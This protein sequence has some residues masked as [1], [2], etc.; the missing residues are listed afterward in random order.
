[1]ASSQQEGRP[2]LEVDESEDVK[3]FASSPPDTG[4]GGTCL[5][6]LMDFFADVSRQLQLFY[7]NHFHRERILVFML[8]VAAALYYADV[9]LDV[10]AAKVF[11]ERDDKLYLAS[12]LGGIGIAG[13]VSS[14]HGGHFVFFQPALIVY[15]AW[16]LLPRRSKLQPSLEPGRVV[17]DSVCLKPSAETL[18]KLLAL[19]RDMALI[20]ANEAFIEAP[21]NTH[22]SCRL[23][24][25][26]AG[27]LV[28]CYAYMHESDLS[29]QDAS[30][31]LLSVIIGIISSGKALAELDKEGRVMESCATI[32]GEF[33]YVVGT[34]LGLLEGIMLFGYRA[35]ETFSRIGLLAHLQQAFRSA[36]PEEF[37]ARLVMAIW[38][39]I[40]AGTLLLLGSR[41]FPSHHHKAIASAFA[42]QGP[43]LHPPHLKVG[44]T[45]ALLH[46]SLRTAEVLAMIFLCHHWQTD[47]KT[48][49]KAAGIAAFAFVLLTPCV[50]FYA[51]HRCTDQ[52]LSDM[53]RQLLPQKGADTLAWPVAD[54]RPS[55]ATRFLAS[56]GFPDDGDIPEGM[57]LRDMNDNEAAQKAMF[58][59]EGVKLVK[60]IDF[61]RSR[62]IMASSWKKIMRTLAGGAAEELMLTAA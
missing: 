50:L 7:H 6:S 34:G 25:V 13:L 54:N 28:Q 52:L 8:C 1:M 44:T 4:T 24:G 19:Q 51:S 15:R 22:L 47:L 55:S 16:K 32:H 53:A 56:L 17:R 62:G 29:E 33:N 11:W 3:G 46:Y 58:K 30:S 60:K 42:F 21:I 10:K 9:I 57:L 37:W 35:I 45:S 59:L 27:P 26:A 18:Q 61:G 14:S 38:L 36:F 41:T 23:E 40:S 20:V 43:L 2:L 49:D 31:L 39:S 5:Q 48:I 12:N